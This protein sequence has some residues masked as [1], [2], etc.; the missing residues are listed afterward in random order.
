M[1]NPPNNDSKHLLP[2][3]LAQKNI[4]KNIQ[5]LTNKNLAQTNLAYQ[6]NAQ[7]QAT[8]AHKISSH[9]KTYL[10]ATIATVAFAI[11]AL[12]VGRY[13][14]S[15]SDIF[16]ILMR[17]SICD[18]VREFVLLD[19]RLPRVMLALVM[20]AGLSMCGCAFQSLFG[21]PLAT[22]DIL[23]VT[24]ASSFGAVLGLLF[25]LGMFGVCVFG[26]GF[27]VLSL[28]LVVAVSY[29]RLAPI[30]SVSMILS[31]I[32]I[33]ALFSSL[34]SLVKY[35]ADPQDT[36]PSITYWLL[37]SLSR[38]WSAE[39]LAGIIVVSVGCVVLFILRWKLNLLALSEEE[40]R[41]LGVNLN[42][43]R[44]V[45]V[46]FATLIVSVSVSLCGVI[47]WVGLLIPHIARLLVGS[48]NSRLL[49]LS[50]ILGALFLV[51]ID[52]ISRSLSSSEIPISILT[53]LLGAP[54]FIYIL[55][56]NKAGV[57]L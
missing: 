56:K 39:L 46:L 55:R 31:G 36:L 8:F 9:C 1:K 29:S 32:I 51:L 47:G 34:V 30:S 52:V 45:V 49:P 20:G 57:K 27:G 16:A 25:G 6:H 17:G 4:I 37:G 35:L 7:H 54:F 21:N 44:F 12:T 48:E 11:F 53:A 40:A 22:P 10:I 5:N 19:F 50:A 41:S 42:L 23:G 24:S 18:E 15:L 33:S 28:V 38:V 3:H 14:I 43:L 26:F 2:K 13:E